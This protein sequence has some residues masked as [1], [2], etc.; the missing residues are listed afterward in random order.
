MKIKY[1]KRPDIAEIDLGDEIEDIVTG[2]RG[3]AVARVL[4]LNGCAQ[5]CLG[6]QREK[7]TTLS[8]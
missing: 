6:A 2:L 3:I 8:L 1:R 5:V 4:Y 7:L